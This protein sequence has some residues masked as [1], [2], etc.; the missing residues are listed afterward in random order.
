MVLRATKHVSFIYKLNDSPG[1]FS[2]YQTIVTSG[3]GDIE[4]FTIADKHYL[5]VANRVG[6]NS[7]IYTWNGHKFVASQNVP[8]NGTTSINYFKILQEP[9]LA[10]TNYKSMN[11]VIYKWKDHQVEKFQEKGTEEGILSLASTAFEINNETFIAFAH[12]KNSQ[13]GYAA[14]STVFKWSGNSF[15]KLQSLQTYGAADFWSPSTSTVTQFLVFANE[16]EGS[17]YNIDSFI[18]KVGWQQVR[19]VSVHPHSWS[20]HLASIRDT[21]SNVPRCG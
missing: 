16:Y 14:N 11:S 13:Q 7:V 8:A 6:L 9:F 20:S 15:V 19:P 17:N 1:K 3:A 5:A 21:Q 12:F 2:L 10:V 4:Y 18:Y